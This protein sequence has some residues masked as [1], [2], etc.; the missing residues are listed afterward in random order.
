M[1]NNQTE[2]NEK[3]PKETKEIRIK[4]KDFQ[5]QLIIEDYL[6]LEKLYLRDIENIEKIILKN[7]PQLK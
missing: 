4:N 2:F 7:L 6:K 3:Y 1:V 5:G